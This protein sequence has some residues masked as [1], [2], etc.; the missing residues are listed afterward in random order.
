MEDITNPPSDE[1]WFN[2]IKAF[3]EEELSPCIICGKVWKR[4]END[5]YVWLQ[6]VGVMCQHHHGVMDFW[7]AEMDKD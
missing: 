5:G 4:K 6:S 7:L 3:S 2:Y 1:K